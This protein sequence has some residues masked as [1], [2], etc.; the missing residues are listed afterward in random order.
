MG[1]K[2]KRKKKVRLVLKKK[3][4]GTSEEENK[5]PKGKL[6]LTFVNTCRQD[7][8][9][10]AGFLREQWE[11]VYNGE[12]PP[13]DKHPYELVKLK[14]EYELF[15]R[16]YELSNTPIPPRV[17]RNIDASREF[18]IDDL[19]PNLQNTM[20]AKI[21]NSQSREDAVKPVD[22]TQGGNIMSKKKNAVPK[23]KVCDTI[24]RVLAAN[25]KG[26]L[27]DVKVAVLMNKAQPEKKC[28]EAKDVKIYRSKYNSG[29]C[30]GMTSK[31]KTLSKCYDKPVASGKDSKVTKVKPKKL[32]LKKKK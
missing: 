18:N 12:F 15:R 24:M 11:E 7:P 2:L 29:R 17:Q 3:V 13:W 26:K 22:I 23:E 5:R 4:A 30:W 27:N 20:R 31:P 32:V 28:N 25:E 9:K 6:L 16:D 14:L 8:R 1:L 10:E 21:N 19:S